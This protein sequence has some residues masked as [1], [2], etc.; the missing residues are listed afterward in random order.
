MALAL[1]TQAAVESPVVPPTVDDQEIVVTAR[2]LSGRWS[3]NISTV[4][5][6]TTCTTVRST[7]DPTFDAIGCR[8]MMTCWPTYLPQIEAQSKAEIATGR[9]KTKEDLQRANLRGELRKTWQNMGKCTFPLLRDGIRDEI[10]RRK[11]AAA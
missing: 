2:K 7:G 6:Q 10:K 4:N 11:A 8:A 5:S 1:A 3:G 9:I